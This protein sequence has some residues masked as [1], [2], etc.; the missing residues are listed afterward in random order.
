MRMLIAVMVML[1]ARVASAQTQLELNLGA[2]ADRD[3]ARRAM[4]ASLDARLNPL[5][6]ANPAQFD[7]EMRLQKSFNE[8]VTKFCEASYAENGGSVAPMCMADCEQAL[9]LYREKQSDAANGK[10]LSLS[11]GL[12]VLVRSKD[13]FSDFYKGLC[14]LPSE[15]WSNQSA[16]KDCEDAAARDMAQAFPAPEEGDVCSISDD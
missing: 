9:Y 5:K 1:A 16:P 13:L 3:T 2:A 4:N 15:L 8:A 12:R 11:G 14:A 10:R 6:K 7:S